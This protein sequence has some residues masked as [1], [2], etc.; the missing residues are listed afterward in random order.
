MASTKGQPITCKAA[1]VWEFKKAIAIETVIVQPPGHKEVRVKIVAAGLCHGDLHCLEGGFPTQKLPCI[2]G[3]EGSGIVESIGEG[4]TSVKPGDKVLTACLPQCRQ[5]DICKD[6]RSNACLDSGRK[7]ERAIAF[8]RSLAY[9]G[10]TRFSCNNKPVYYFAGCSAFSEY[11]VIPEN[12]CIKIDPKANIEKACL[13]ACAI[14]TGYGIAAKANMKPGD[15]VAI[16]GVGGVGLATVLACK[17]NKAGKIIGIASSTQKESIARKMGCTDFLAVKGLDKPVPQVIKE[18]TNGGLDF[19]F[20]CVG[21]AKTMEDAIFCT[22]PGGTTIMVGGAQQDV[23]INPGFLLQDRKIA[24]SCL[25]GYKTVD[26][27]PQLVKKSMKGD[28]PLD[29]FISGYF[30]L[31]QINEMVDLMHSGKSL[32]SV[33]LMEK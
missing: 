7:E 26:E 12:S 29:D 13:C 1:V 4:V 27:L 22:K 11:T 18:I 25:G 10:T 17:H 2:L 24:G 9:D 6:G 19:A 16:W 21:D 20:V 23:K 31:E 3:H 14:P 15:N 30:K 33:I 5:C 8:L 28:I 32:R